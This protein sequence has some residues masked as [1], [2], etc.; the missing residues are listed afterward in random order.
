[1][2]PMRPRQ[3]LKKLLCTLP[4]NWSTLHT[5]T[6]N[7]RTGIAELR[8]DTSSLGAFRLVQVLVWFNGDLGR[9]FTRTCSMSLG[10][11]F[12]SLKRTA[13]KWRLI[14]VSGSISC[15]RGIASRQTSIFDERTAKILRA[16]AAVFTRRRVNSV[17]GHWLAHSN[18]SY[19]NARGLGV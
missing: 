17:A 15:K 10:K 8:L 9:I 7:K 11:R 5:H 1:M 16:A 4:V 18:Q 6:G 19:R 14:I 3:N 2:Q 13:F 12:I